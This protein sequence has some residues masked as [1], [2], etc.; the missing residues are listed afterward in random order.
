MDERRGRRLLQFAREPRPGT[1]KTRML[2]AL[3]AA[4]ACAL[5][6]ALL[7][8]TAHR[9]AL[10][11]RCARELWV[12]G[13]PGHPL[14][15]R[16]CVRGAPALHRQRGADLGERMHHALEEALRRGRCAVLVGSDCPALDARYV[17]AAFT[18]L[19]GA[20][21]VLGPALDGGYVLVGLR[22]PAPFLFEDV[23]WG[24]DAVLATTLRRAASRGCEPV[25]LPAL[26]DIDG[27][28]DLP[29]WRAESDG[30]ASRN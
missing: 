26:Q 28:E 18:A 17:E 27:P 1:V 2:P 24:T 25:L 12:E 29:A 10:V 3:T 20:D 11:K 23:P 16:L 21:V 14:F 9:L 7:E 4:Q 8:H 5:H 15:R 30:T 13:D 22:R 19:A 6:V